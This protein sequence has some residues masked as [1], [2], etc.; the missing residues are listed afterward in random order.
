MVC[1][2]D[3][4]HHDNRIFGQPN[5]MSKSYDQ[6][7]F[8]HWYRSQPVGDADHYLRKAQLAVAVTEYYLERPIQ[9]VLDIG[10]GEGQWFVLLKQLRPNIRYLGFDSSDYAVSRFGQER[11][12][13][14]AQFGDFDMLR[15]CEPVDLLVC[16]DVM[17][18]VPDDELKRGI[19][20]LGDLCQGVA[21]LET[22]T[23]EDELLGDDV[24]FHTRP[25]SFYRKLF[26]KQGFTPLGNHCWLS[27]L[28]DASGLTALEQ[29][30]TP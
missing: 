18:Y 28:L 25:A 11:H 8:D 16:S 3:E 24:D 5:N 22:F 30:R 20:G 4:T 17:H 23:R 2:V 6:A 15:P 12:L 21:F 1:F 9:T 13:H 10:C 29:V 7:Y 19:V 26:N 14:L 27:P